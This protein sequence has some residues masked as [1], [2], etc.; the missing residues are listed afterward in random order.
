M[1]NLIKAI[2]W[3]TFWI[4]LAIGCL[5]AFLALCKVG[6]PAEWHWWVFPIIMLGPTA[7]LVVAFFAYSLLFCAIPEKDVDG[8]YKYHSMRFGMT[9]PR[10]VPIWSKEFLDYYKWHKAT[11]GNKLNPFDPGI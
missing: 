10:M 7:L 8:G 9:K 5:C 4:T 11:F 2:I 6:Y 3:P 1:K